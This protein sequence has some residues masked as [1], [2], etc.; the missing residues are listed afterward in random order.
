MPHT[1]ILHPVGQRIQEE[2]EHRPDNQALT[3][4]LN[5]KRNNSTGVDHEPDPSR[6]VNISPEHGKLVQPVCN[7]YSGSP[8]EEDMQG[9]PKIFSSRTLAT[10]VVSDTPSDIIFKLRQEYSPLGMSF[11]R[12]VN[13]S[14]SLTL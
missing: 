2:H 11:S 5:P 7:L 1:S 13:F 4:N 10:E 12:S 6:S 3:G 14:V 8:S 9:N